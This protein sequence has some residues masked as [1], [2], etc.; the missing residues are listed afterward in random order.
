M[1]RDTL[2]KHKEFVVIC[3][4]NGSIIANYN[5]LITHLESKSIAQIVVIYVTTKQ[6]LTYSNC[7]KIGHAKE[8]S[9]QERNTCITCYFH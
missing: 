3:E 1:A 4:E 2:I 9:Q 7:G 5:A 6:P 8:N